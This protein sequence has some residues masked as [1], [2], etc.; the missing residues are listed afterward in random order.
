MPD[1]IPEPNNSSPGHR[2]GLPNPLSFWKRLQEDRLR[3]QR[4]EVSSYLRAA[5]PVA[6]AVNRLYEDWREAISEPVQDGQK[7]ANLSAN[8]WWQVTDRLRKFQTLEPPNPAQRYHKLF[9]DALR[10]ASE[11]AEVVKNGFRFNKYVDISRGMGFLDRYVE[12][13][14]GAESELRRL[15]SR[16]QLVENGAKERME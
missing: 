3:H 7:A 16:Y 8:Y 13:M 6:L 5:T 12:L 4:A 15:V 9:L 10:N 14:A 1:P 2:S 11:G